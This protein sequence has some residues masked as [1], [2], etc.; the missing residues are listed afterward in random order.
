MSDDAD[1]QL[2][3]SQGQRAFE[4]G[5][6]Q[7]AIQCFEQGKTIASVGTALHGELQIWLV[8]AYEAAGDRT[9]ALDLCRIIG[10]HPDL[11][12]RKQSKQLLYILEAPKLRMNPEWLTE[13]PDLT[14]I[15]PNGDDRDWGRPVVNLTPPRPPKLKPPKGYVI[16]EPTDPTQVNMGDDR[17]ILW[18]AIA[19]VG[20][21]L[22]VLWAG[23]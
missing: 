16:P 17:S 9:R 8:M 11:E 21:L 20:V 10:A 12:T 6:Y 14:E 3:L 18:A 2:F 15:E 5:Q 22:G 23:R 7:R 1:S 4:C 13:I 19:A